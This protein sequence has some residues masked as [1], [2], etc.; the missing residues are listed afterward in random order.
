MKI[1]P[2]IWPT[3]S[4]LA[5]AIGVPYPTAHAW[6][7]R[8]VPPRR[9]RSLIAAAA[10]SGHVLTFDQLSNFEADLRADAGTAA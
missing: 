7:R 2:Q 4:A 9:F 1:V 10:K 8:G 6:A 3:W 5:D